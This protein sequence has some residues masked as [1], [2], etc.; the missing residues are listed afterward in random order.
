M[1]TLNER[2]LL[3]RIQKMKDRRAFD[4][5]YGAYLERIAR[6]IGMKVPDQATADELTNEVFIKLW[7]YLI[8]DE[9]ISYLKALIYRIARTMIADF[10]RARQMQTVSLNDDQALEVPSKDLPLPDRMDQI[11]EKEKLKRALGQLKE[12]YR[13]AV[14][15]RYLD[16]MTIEEVAE[17][18]EKTPG[19]V[20]VLIHR[21]LKALEEIIQGEPKDAPEKK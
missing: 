19:T 8:E 20:R 3:F 14:T 12:S 13:E 11:I 6:F 15:L 5:L 18:L 2:F 9:P 21:A 17:A 7:K 1:P 10:Y 16:E 4:V